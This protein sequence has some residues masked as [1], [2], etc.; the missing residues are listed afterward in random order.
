MTIV[1]E[2]SIDKE[3][4]ITS[5]KR[6]FSAKHRILMLAMELYM[7]IL[8]HISKCSYPLFNCW[9]ENPTHND[10][11]VTHKMLPENVS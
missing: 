5:I 10:I 4:I 11:P 1:N 9:Y 3:L 6:I 7:N 2:D 8:E